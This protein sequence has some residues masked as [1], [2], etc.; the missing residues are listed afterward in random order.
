[1]SKN[2]KKTIAELRG[3]HKDQILDSD[4]MDQVTGGKRSGSWLRRVYHSIVPQ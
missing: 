4:K 2:G 1:M 3:D